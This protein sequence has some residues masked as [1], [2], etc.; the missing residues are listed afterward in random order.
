[1]VVFFCVGAFDDGEIEAEVEVR[2]CELVVG[3]AAEA[4][5]GGCFHGA[6]C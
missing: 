4:L 6:C 3:L 1:M 2:V 5:G